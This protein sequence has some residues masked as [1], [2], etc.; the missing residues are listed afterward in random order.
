MTIQFRRHQ[1]RHQ[2][3]HQ[4]PWQPLPQGQVVTLLCPRCLP[5][6]GVAV[7]VVAVVGSMTRGIVTYEDCE[8]LRRA[9]ERGDSSHTWGPENTITISTVTPQNDKIG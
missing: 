5:R 3:R 1:S 2:S 6:V 7:G 4:C 8:T 9:G